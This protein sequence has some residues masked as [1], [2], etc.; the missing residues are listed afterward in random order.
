MALVRL[1]WDYMPPPE[2]RGNSRAH[3]SVRHKI[4][5]QFKEATTWRLMEIDPDPMDKVKI[6]YIAHWCGKPIDADNLIKGM[7]PALDALTEYG[8]I[9][10]DNPEFVKG[11]EVEYHRVKQ[12]KQIKMIMEV[13][14][15]GK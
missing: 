5:K 2:L 1:E 13:S 9:E 3:W 10:D 7:K 15:G 11:I 4:T 12:K 8:L 6:K 14:E